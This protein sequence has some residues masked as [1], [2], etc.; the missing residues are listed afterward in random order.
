MAQKKSA[1]GAK[2]KKTT[3]SWKMHPARG[4]D[5]TVHPFRITGKSR[6]MLNGILQKFAGFKPDHGSGGNR[7]FLT[8]TWITTF[9]LRLFFN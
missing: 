2:G 1:S 4:H 7:N 3:S 6:S 9:S 8:C 5:P